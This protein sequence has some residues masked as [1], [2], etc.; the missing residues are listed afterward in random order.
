MTKVLHKFNIEGL[1]F[2]DEPTSG[3]DS[4]TANNIV[5]ILLNLA[6]RGRTVVCTIHQP[7]SAIFYMF[8][9]VLKTFMYA[10]N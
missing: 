1:L 10:L 5:G 7:R 4:T 6:R 9:Q 2:L 3:L 8:D